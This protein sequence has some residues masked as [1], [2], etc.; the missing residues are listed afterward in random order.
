MCLMISSKLLFY[1][2]IKY[3]EKRLQFEIEL[4]KDDI[5]K[6]LFV[7]LFLSVYNFHSIDGL[8]E[9]NSLIQTIEHQFI[10]KNNYWKINKVFIYQNNLN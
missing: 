8:W 7:N 4:D 3:A 5:Y 10:S 2:V 6:Y 1:I 9:Q